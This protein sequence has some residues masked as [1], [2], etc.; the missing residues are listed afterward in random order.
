MLFFPIS[1][2]LVQQEFQQITSFSAEQQWQI[3]Y[4][5]FQLICSIGQRKSMSD[6]LIF[7]V[8]YSDGYAYYFNK[9]QNSI[10]APGAHSTGPTYYNSKVMLYWD[11]AK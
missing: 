6:H 11:M 4:P 10:H 1:Y 8:T 3:V 5:N 2:A 7:T 9:A